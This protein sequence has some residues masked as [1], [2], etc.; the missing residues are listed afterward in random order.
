MAYR[1][2]FRGQNGE[3]T[4]RNLDH[5]VSGGLVDAEGRRALIYGNPWRGF[6]SPPVPVLHP[7]GG[8]ETASS[9]QWP[10]AS[11]DGGPR[12]CTTGNSA[13]NCSFLMRKL[14]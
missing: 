10:V 2:K 9:E 11:V 4:P 1:R 12:P 7:T 8:R 13:Q 14:I 6:S 5:P 3:L